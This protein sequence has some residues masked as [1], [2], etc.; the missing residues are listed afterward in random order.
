LLDI[1]FLFWYAVR[2]NN[3]EGTMKESTVKAI[4]ALGLDPNDFS[5]ENVNLKGRIVLANPKDFGNN[6]DNCL[7]RATDG[8]GCNPELIGR[9]VFVERLSDGQKG[10][11]D[12]SDVIAVQNEPA[13]APAA[14][15]KE[16]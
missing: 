7:F 14:P 16:G 12:R 1:R 8:F 15:A 4:K 3:G 11:I 13:Q 10:R 5:T 9:A 2:I 6:K